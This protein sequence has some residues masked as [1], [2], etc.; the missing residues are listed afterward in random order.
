MAVYT[1][2]TNE[3]I[4]SAIETDYTI[5]TLSFAVGITQGVENTN[6]LI[7]TTDWAGAE[8]KYILTLY[9]KRMDPQELPFFIALMHHLAAQGVSCPRPIARKD[10]ALFGIIEGKPAA[11]VSFV[12]GKSRTVLANAHVASVGGALAGLHVATA[13]FGMERVNRLSLEGWQGIYSKIQGKLDAI[14]DGLEMLVADELAYLAQHWNQIAELPRGVIHA[15]LFPDNVFFDGDHVSGLIDF[16]FACSDALAYDVAIT[17]NAWCFETRGGE[18][19]PIK[20]NLF[21]SHYQK[22][23]ALSDAEI[24]AFPLLL[25]GAALRFLLTRAHDWIF[26]DPNAQVNAKDPME[27]A[28]KLRFHQHVRSVSEY[29]LKV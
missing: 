5:G 14:Y 28:A 17:L 4:A 8:Q 12:N 19:N 7:A 15:D 13:D 29:G 24:A 23:R 20:S 27:Y 21:L 10:G 11:I 16:Y 2:L 22:T 1:Q 26:R 3:Q 9:E 6:Y 18:F 25:R